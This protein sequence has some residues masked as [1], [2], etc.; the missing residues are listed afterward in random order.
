[1]RTTSAP[2]GPRNPYA[3]CPAGNRLARSAR[4]SS[5]PNSPA[6]AATPP[7]RPAGTACRTDRPRHLP[8]VTAPPEPTT[9]PCSAW[10]MPLPLSTGEGRTPHPSPD[11]HPYTPHPEAPRMSVERQDLPAPTP[12]TARPARTP[13]ALLEHHRALLR[14]HGQQQHTECSQG[15]RPS[16]GAPE[17][18]RNGTNT[19]SRGLWA[20]SGPREPTR[21]QVMR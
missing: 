7:P 19:D 16:C 11:P 13:S 14:T 10:T 6:T 12:S 3:P 2:D 4:A 21:R 8:T 1:M 17:R 15:W 18:S 5:A 20:I 9:S